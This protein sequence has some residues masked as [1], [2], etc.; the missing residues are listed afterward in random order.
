[1]FVSKARNLVLQCGAPEMRFTRV[2][3]GLTCKHDTKLERLARDKQSRLLRKFI[4]QRQKLFITL[5][6]GWSNCC[7]W[8]SG[9][10]VIKTFFSVTD[11]DVK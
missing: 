3:S 10:N 2:G 11:E 9:V 8:R 4:N 5:A 1:M 6:P 7:T